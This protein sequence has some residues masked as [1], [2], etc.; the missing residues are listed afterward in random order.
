MNQKLFYKIKQK[1]TKNNTIKYKK[2]QSKNNELKK[3]KESRPCQKRRNKKDLQIPYH[4][5]II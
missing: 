5:K 4:N 1:T 2:V 3:G